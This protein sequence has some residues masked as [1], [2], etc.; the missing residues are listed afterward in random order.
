M[1]QETDQSL[2]VK[3]AD[4]TYSLLENCQEKQE[5]IAEQ[6]NISISEFK[7]LRSF[8]QDS[9]LSV[10]EIAGRMGLTSSR[11]TR[12]IDGLVEKK[13]VTRD[14]NA[15][16][17]RLMDVAL[18]ESG[19]TVAFQLDKDYT[20]LHSQ[21]LS[22]IDPASREAVIFALENLSAAMQSWIEKKDAAEM[23]QDL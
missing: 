6:L 14:I 1:K 7:C 10:K 21:I 22:N 8:H 15:H 19:A 18:T 5:Y 9:V 3:M 13:F 17:R 12:I 20:K 16:D 2:A 23:F 4:L 11:L